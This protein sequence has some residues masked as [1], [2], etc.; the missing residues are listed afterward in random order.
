MHFTEGIDVGRLTVLLAVGLFLLPAMEPAAA[1]APSHD[2]GPIVAS[3]IGRP[4]AEAA[5]PAQ[6]RAMAERA[7]LLNAIRE[8]AR[9]AGRS[10]PESFTG[11]VRVGA[12]IEG[13]RITRIT[14]LPDGTVEIEVTVPPAG[15]RP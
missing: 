6:A 12:T 5:S 2:T 15:V 11:P 1:Q 14:S 9:L 13:F 8:A 3:G 10:V 7:A 4:P